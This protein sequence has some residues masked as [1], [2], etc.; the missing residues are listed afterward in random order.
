[1]GMDLIRGQKSAVFYNLSSW[2]II[3]DLARYGGW[4]PAGTR[5]QYIENWTG[6]Y[7]TNDGQRVSVED[8]REMAKAIRKAV[9]EL[10]YSK[11]DLDIPTRRFINEARFLLDDRS[12]E[13]TD[14]EE[15]RRVIK[16]LSTPSDLTL[17]AKRLS[18]EARIAFDEP[19]EKSTRLEQLLEFLDGGEFSIW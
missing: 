12:T 1:M 19:L 18:P 8:A 6:N 5:N 2:H 15:V 13:S 17:R 14:M 10:F 16:N 7:V 11:T 3:L 4:E 9:D